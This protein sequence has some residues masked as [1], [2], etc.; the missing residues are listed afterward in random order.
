MAERQIK[1][2]RLSLPAS[3]QSGPLLITGG[4]L[5]IFAAQFWPNLPAVT[6]IAL[7]GRGAVLTLQSRPRTVRQDSLL[8]VNLAVYGVLVCLAIVA[9]SN[10]VLESGSSARL[11]MLLDHSLAIVLVLGLIFRVFQQL[12]QPTG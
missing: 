7:I 2:H 9:Q 12:S 4:V 1:H 3:W 10:A 8:V 5:L 11:G 6:A